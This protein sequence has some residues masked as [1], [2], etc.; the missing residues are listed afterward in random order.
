MRLQPTY[1]N[2]RRLRQSLAERRLP[3][4]EAAV[5]MLS[6]AMLADVLLQLDPLELARFQPLLGPGRLADALAE[7]DASEAAR[8]IARFSRAIAADILE[9]MEPDD[10]TDVVEELQRE[11]AEEILGEMEGADA[12]EIRDLMKHSPDTAGGRMTPEFV[13]IS[14]RITVAV[15]MRL[16]RTQAPN[17]ETIYYVYATESDDRLVGVVSLRDL[18]VADP[19]TRISEVMRHQ[20]IRV[21]ADV[22]QEVV[23]RLFAEHDL[24]ALPVVDDADRLLGVITVDDVMDVVKQEATEDMYRMVGVGVKERATS[25]LWESAR[26]R[27]PWLGFNMVWSLGSALVISGFQGTKKGWRSSPCSCRLSQGRRVT[28]ASRRRPS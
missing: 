9:D 21:R 13:S 12:Q 1:L 10:A 6:P 5:S 17:A 19:Q 25:P 3:E 23:A 11:Q 28:P 26:R 22:D 16:I 8:L 27:V 15:A 2:V 24:L 4:A 18:V 14:P 7:L 20:V